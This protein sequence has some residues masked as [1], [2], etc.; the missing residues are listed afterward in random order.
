V[1][2]LHGAIQP[3]VP[4]QFLQREIR[5]FAE[6]HADAL[7]MLSL[8]LRL[9]PGK[10][11]PRSDR[12]SLPP[13]LEELFDH[14]QGHSEAPGDV[15]AGAFLRVVG[16]EN[17]FPQIQGDRSAIAHVAYHGI[18]PNQWLYY[19]L[20]RSRPARRNAGAADEDEEFVDVR[21]GESSGTLRIERR[22]EPKGWCNRETAL[23]TAIPSNERR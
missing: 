10:M 23:A 4:A 21:R 7:A 20:N 18:K 1:N 14:A 22:R 6:Q 13:L 8:N 5:L 16:V 17:A 3:Q 12:A 2:G 19:L 15:L 9:P 11:M